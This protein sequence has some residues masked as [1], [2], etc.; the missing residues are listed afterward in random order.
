MITD[1]KE[2]ER[3]RN[4]GGEEKRI[5]Y[6]LNE[7]SIVFDVGGYTGN[8]GVKMFNK[9]NC[10][11]YSFEPVKNFYSQYKSKIKSSKFK[12]FNYGI[13]DK[14]CSMSINVSN[15]STSLYR[16]FANKETIQLR[17]I[18]SVI[19][20]LLITNIDL[21]Q[22]NIEGGEY[23]VLNRIIDTGKI[24][25]IKRLQVQF[26]DIDTNSLNKKNNIITKLKNSHDLIWKYSEWIWELWQMKS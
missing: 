3:W 1:T 21:M 22:I 25:T 4:E 14:D 11:L 8:W 6:P 17:D 15:D 23:D 10:N 20:E 24:N 5:N 26:H 7:N 18:S 12:I 13:L 9:Y 16:N 19:D 2:M